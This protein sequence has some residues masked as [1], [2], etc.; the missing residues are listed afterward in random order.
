MPAR[1]EW[2]YI[3]VGGGLA[4]VIVAVRLSDNPGTRVLLLEAGKRA[5]S[6][7]LAIP[8]VETMLV[9]HP[10]YDWRFETE[11]DPTLNGR[12]VAVPCGRLLGG[13]NAIN[14]M[15][16]VRGQR[17]DYDEW[18]RQGAAGWAWRDVLPWFRMA[19][20]WVGGASETRGCGGPMRVELP[21]QRELLCDVFVQAACE[22][23]YRSN[24]D[25]NSGDQEGFGY[26]QCTQRSGRRF[27]VLDGYLNAG[28]R[29]NL[30]V[31][32]RALARRLRFC[33]HRCVGVDYEIGTEM[34]S[35]FAAREVVLSAG[36]VGSPRLLELSGIGDPVVL[37]RAG[38][39][40]LCPS[41]RVGENF[42]DHFATRLRWRISQR[43]TF[44]ERLRG[45]ALAR[46]GMRYLLWRRGV[47]SMPIA[48]AFGFV[49]S[50]SEEKV[51][52]LQ[53]HFAP[54]SYGS[55]SR[56]RLESNP[57]M[58]IGI[59][60]SRPEARGS[61]H[62][63]SSDPRQPP[64]I[65]ARFLSKEA[66]IRRL[67]AGIRIARDIVAAPAFGPYRE[68][69]LVPGPNLEERETLVEHLRVEGST[70]FHPV[71]TCG[72][73]DDDAVVDCALRV[74]GVE[75][76]RVIDASVMPTMISGNTQAATIMIAERGA[77][78]MLRGAD[79]VVVQ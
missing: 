60:P 49:R 40:T 59:Y 19:E 72:L 12:R 57:G 79:A 77:A 69:E 15:L 16:F 42:Q 23:G 7:I 39:T 29:P 64:A 38:V 66:D 36:T 8:A 2:D 51:P 26:Y 32:S 73:G 67:V 62:I 58:T 48:I 53:F 71:G 70:S 21:R 34:H 68:R 1:T 31:R 75:A 9:G 52:D 14:G 35:A 55:G 5:R 20:D 33:R 46:E 61:V 37:A 65:R 11:P 47:L 4:G 25:Y 76:L 3:V 30:T 18:E 74:R 54:A 17:D 41:S 28:R 56:R 22:A 27:S 45:L 43:V 24:P 44:N 13:S 10:R 6:P 63:R 78:M 50:S